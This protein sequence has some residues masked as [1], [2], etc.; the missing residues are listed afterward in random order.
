MT[1]YPRPRPKAMTTKSTTPYL[2]FVVVASLVVSC[3]APLEVVELPVV[4]VEL[5]VVDAVLS[6]VLA[7]AVGLVEFPEAEV[8]TRTPPEEL[9][10]DAE[11]VVEVELS[12]L[13][14]EVEPELEP[15]LVVPH[16]PLDV[17]LCQSPDMSE[18]A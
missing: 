9:F 4:L 6:V 14:E 17:M 11:E 5:P 1:R 15:E 16:F 8:W 2:D 7:V 10:T 13:L 3:A 12:L 18:Y